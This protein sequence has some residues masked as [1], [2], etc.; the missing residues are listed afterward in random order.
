MKIS[1]LRTLLERM[2]PDDTKRVLVEIYRALP[3][4]TREG[5]GIDE[6]LNNP[7]AAGSRTKQAKAQAQ[8]VDIDALAAELEQFLS[9]AYAQNYFA[10][11]RH[12]P[13]SER[14]KWRF[15]AKRFFKEINAAVSDRTNLEQASD[16][17]ER[18]Y[19]MLCYACDYALFNTNDAFQSVGIT[20]TEFL[21]AVL[22]LKAEHLE[23][24]EFIGEGLRLVIDSEL[25]RETLGSY[26]ARVLINRLRTPESLEQA[27]EQA[28]GLY[29]RPDPVSEEAPGRRAW[30]G[31]QAYHSREQRNRLAEFGFLAYAKLS[32]Y[33]KAIGFLRLHYA[34]TN[35]EVLLYVV[36]DWLR[37]FGQKALWMREYEQAIQTGIEPRQSLSQAYHRLKA[38]GELP[39]YY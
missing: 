13:K 23:L 4:K 33:E 3:P 34:A 26:L 31:A 10:P 20:Q 7:T 21:D 36:L 9:D 11:N 2:S 22:G 18:L 17:L 6:L 27:I 12:V 35:Q 39:N 1:E 24:H 16:L 30:D 29:A 19:R 32:D 14:P 28:A 37:A 8:P 15:K 5:L 38:H 25:S